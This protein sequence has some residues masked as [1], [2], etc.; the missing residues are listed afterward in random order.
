MTGPDEGRGMPDSHD[1]GYSGDFADLEERLRSALDR[2]ARDLVPG[3]RLDDIRARLSDDRPPVRPP[4]LLPLA[5]AAAVAAITLVA[6][7]GIRQGG[8]T[9]PV[10]GNTS[11]AAPSVTAPTP[12]GL[13]TTSTAPTSPLVTTPP[14]PTTHRALPVYFVEQVGSDRWGLVR[15]FTTYPVPVGADAAA[16]GAASVDLSV[17]GVPR[18]ATTTVL[19]AWV[20]STF[21][22][23]RLGGSEIGVVLSQPGKAG[24]TDEQQRVAVQQV[25]WAVT[26]GVQQDKPVR[27]TVE[28]G[29]PIFERQPAGVYKRPAPDQVGRDVAPIWVDGPS[30]GSALP[31]SSAVVITGQ[32]CTFEANVAWR[33][34]QGG[35]SVKNGAVTASVACPS[36]GSWR[37]DLGI[38]RTGDYTFHAIETSAKDGSVT[39]DQKLTFTVR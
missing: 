11:S 38:L 31:A 24:L 7:L 18:L 34:E 1:S 12:S 6:W 8:V 10:A 5:A 2:E 4:W 9:L 20:P 22:Q 32:A 19:T 39:A 17:Q 16:L 3:E 27:I 37:V 26:A 25:V 29:G 23:I 14:G 21:A 33:L 13:L 36:L 28:G 30:E 35:T 15:E